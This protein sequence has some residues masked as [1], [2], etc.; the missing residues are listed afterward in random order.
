M[1]NRFTMNIDVREYLRINPISAHELTLSD[2]AND[3]FLFF[4]PTNGYELKTQTQTF[5]FL[6]EKIFRRLINVANDGSISINAKILGDG[7]IQ[8]N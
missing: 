8:W 4:L 1:V 3:C 2:N 7:S 6:Y 5:N